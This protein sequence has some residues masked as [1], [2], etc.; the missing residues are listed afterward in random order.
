M[1]GAPPT[2]EKRLKSSYGRIPQAASVTGVLIA[3]L[4][5]VGW[6]LD[7]EHLRNVLPSK[8]SIFPHDMAFGISLLVVTTIVTLAALIW[9][10]VSSLYRADAA[11]AKAETAL[12]KAYDEL[13]I[14]L[15]ER[16]AELSNVNEVLRLEVIEREQ[17]EDAQRRLLHR[18]VTVQEVERSR[19]ARE[20]HDQTAQYLGALL[21]E[22]KLLKKSSLSQP[23]SRVHLVRLQELAEQL[24][25]EVH[26]LA[27]GLRPPALDELGL[28]TALLNYV[29]K[30]AE[31]SGIIVDFHSTGLDHERLP[32]Q[33]E[34]TLYRFVQEALTN[35][36]KHARAQRMSLILERR[37]DQV[38][39][40]VEDDGCGF[41]AESVTKLPAAGGRLGILGMQERVAMVGGRLGIES[42]PG[43]G[44][45]LVVRIPVLE[46]K[47]PLESEL[48]EVAV[49]E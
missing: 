43:A 46:N 1:T 49:C 31:Y 29:N 8:P 19:I 36:L 18:F 10:T 38:L 24:E 33:V 7:S 15:A 34:T 28:Q 4:V 42:R 5:F 6:L 23:G 44:T 3:S 22:I 16:T 12:R 40:V 9:W 11:R 2:P 48:R 32:P 30:W 21:L 17:A 37:Y 20:L 13:E 27:R 25:R 45:T 41:N 39:C 47:R 26:S 35:A 14:R